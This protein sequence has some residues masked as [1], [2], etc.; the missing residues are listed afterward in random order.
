MCVEQPNIT[1]AGLSSGS[2]SGETSHTQPV[3][4]ET[5]PN[6]ALHSPKQHHG[7]GRPRHGHQGNLPH[8]SVARVE[9]LMAR[10]D[11]GSHCLLGFLVKM[12]WCCWVLMSCQEVTGSTPTSSTQHSSHLSFIM[13]ISS[14]EKLHFNQ[15]FSAPWRPKSL[16]RQGR[17]Q[18]SIGS[19]FTI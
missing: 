5:W 1:E 3:S 8:P 13:S 6:T 14:K 10:S 4:T 2:G 11:P 17:C 7:P 12:K 16:S 18:H 19:D 9:S 15:I